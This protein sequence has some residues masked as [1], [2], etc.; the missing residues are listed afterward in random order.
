[1]ALAPER[2][3]TPD[4]LHDVSVLS[5][6]IRRLND[7][8]S[9]SLATDQITATA[10]RVERS[11]LKA[12]NLFEHSRLR[13][14][15]ASQPDEPLTV[16]SVWSWAER[17][18]VAPNVKCRPKEKEFHFTP[19]SKMAWR[20][21]RDCAQIPWCTGYYTVHGPAKNPP[22]QYPT[23]LYERPTPLS[24]FSHFVGRAFQAAP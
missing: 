6:T 10:L 5:D 21:Y 13:A 4:R 11:I 22:I 19:Y 17:F 7:T 12:L 1:M 14:P 3:A 20:L 15:A 9:R 24:W 18:S 8:S 16:L 2:Q 23:V